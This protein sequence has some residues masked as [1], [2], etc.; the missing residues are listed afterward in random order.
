MRRYGKYN[1]IKTVIDG[2][3]FD[4]RLEAQRWC[5]LRLLEKGGVI[6]NL[7]RQVV[8]ELQ[9]GFKKNG[10]TYRPIKYIADFVYEENGQTVVEDTKGCLTDEYRLKKKLFEYRYRNLTIKEV[11]RR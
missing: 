3:E 5:E 9:P 4:S 2:I 1:A 11:K 10:V 6:N 7:Q 8:F